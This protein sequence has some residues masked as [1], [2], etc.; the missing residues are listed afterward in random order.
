MN[1][2][3]DPCSR[4][5]EL[6]IR[7][8]IYQ[9]CGDGHKGRGTR[10]K[11]FSFDTILTRVHRLLFGY[12]NDFCPKSQEL[13]ISLSKKIL[14]D[15]GQYVKENNNDDFMFLDKKS[16][17]GLKLRLTADLVKLHGELEVEGTD[18]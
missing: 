11:S 6:I 18:R 7:Y 16:A 9:I 5:L 1:P 3:Y 17:K 13:I 2:I 4:D 10:R 8:S 14:G 15:Y 12:G